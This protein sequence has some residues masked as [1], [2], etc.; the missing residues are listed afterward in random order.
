MKTLLQIASIGSFLLSPGF[1]LA[2]M[3]PVQSQTGSPVTTT[4]TTKAWMKSYVPPYMTYEF[5][6]T[7]PPAVLD[8][9]D[10]RIDGPQ[11]CGDYVVA[12]FQT[13]GEESEGICKHPAN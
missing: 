10:G 1:C 3:T 11:S 12:F 13:S 8:K 5:L 2:E 4:E 7:K 6:H 9:D